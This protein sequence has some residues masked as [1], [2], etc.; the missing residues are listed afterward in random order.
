M[1]PAGAMDITRYL[2]RQI[3]GN[4]TMTGNGLL[5]TVRARITCML[6][7]MALLH[8][9]ANAAGQGPEKKFNP[10]HYI[11]MNSWDAQKDIKGAL[12]PGVRGVQKRYYWKK[13]EPALDNYDFSEVRSD[14]DLLAAQGSQLVV[15]IEDKSF[16]NEN[17]MPDY[18]QQDYSLKNR[19]NGYTA[20]RWSPYVVTRFSALIAELG[21]QFDDHPAFEGVAI[22]ESAHGIPDAPAA[23]AGYTPEKYRDSIIDV[24][25]TAAQTM[26]KSQVFWYMNFLPGNMSY[27]VDIARAVGP[28]G[29]GMGGPDVLPD[30]YAL[31][32]HTYPLFQ[33]LEGEILMFNSLQYNSYNHVHKDTSYGT[34]YWTLNQLF[35]FARD[36]LHVRY[37]FW[38]RKVQAQPSDSYDW[39]DALEVIAAN[40]TFNGGSES[41]SPDSDSDND[42][43]TYSQELEL[44]TNPYK[45]DTDG[46]TLSDGD[47]HLVTGTNPL[48]RNTDNDGIHDGLEVEYGLS[49]PFVRDTDSDGLQD[50]DEIFFYK[51]SARSADTDNDGLSDYL[52]IERYGTDALNGDSDADGLTDGQEASESGIGTNPLNPD[53]DSGGAT[54]GEEVA[55]GTNPLMKSDDQVGFVDPDN[56]GLSDQQEKISGSNPN[57]WDTDGDGLG[58]GDEVNLY[59][60]NPLHRNT[61]RDGLNDFVEVVYKKT[62]PLK[63]DTDGDGLTD[64]Q[65]ARI[66]GLGTNP[67]KADTDG[68]GAGDGWE[69]SRGTNPRYAGDD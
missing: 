53:S 8:A 23:A 44:G 4:Y 48:L 64:G 37:L 61:D 25:T 1:A 33:E 6:A 36:Q 19:H 52:E 50:G 30:D 67:L 10:G 22:Q 57:K 47:E 31:D 41:V 29:V 11:S 18:L 3:E 54:D 16:K 13:L 17:P 49:N 69:V 62:N 26:P 7:L 20:I 68:G 42:G 21:R 5:M 60:T 56:D 2:V 34:K 35:G 39:L 38:N 58:D 51:T 14:L 32:R 12:Q 24:L 66:G 63:K 43:L 65:E 28:L 15:F 59:G 45:K 40:P 27:I 9:T 55:N 46:D